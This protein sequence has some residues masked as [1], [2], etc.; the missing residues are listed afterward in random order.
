MPL[1]QNKYE[2][3]SRVD[4]GATTNIYYTKVEQM[5]SYTGMIAKQ[6]P[7][8]F[9]LFMTEKG[10]WDEHVGCHIGEQGSVSCE[11]DESDFCKH[12]IDLFVKAA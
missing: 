9:N 8:F 4:E 2:F 7:E 10:T 12:S 11:K 1:L 5:G 3:I 6:C